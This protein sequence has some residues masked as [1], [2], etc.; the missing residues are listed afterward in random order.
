MLSSS[1]VCACKLEFA[2]ADG[3][4]AITFINSEGEIV[5][6][7][8]D[9]ALDVDS[10]IS[11]L[12]AVAKTPECE[13]GMGSLFCEGGLTVEDV[14]GTITAVIESDVEIISVTSAGVEVAGVK[15][16]TTVKVC[17]CQAYIEVDSD[18]SSFEIQTDLEVAGETL[19]TGTYASGDAATLLAD[20]E[21]ALDALGVTYTSVEV[22]ENVKEGMFTVCIYIVGD[23]GDVLYNCTPLSSCGC[24]QEYWF[25]TA[26][27]GEK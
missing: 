16:C 13:S 25:E 12:T 27:E 26:T 6:N 20:W 9:A 8:F 2:A 24:K 23:C 10:V 11:A 14:D 3:I 21:T 5:T 19:A 4:E 15:D 22:T 1:A 7:S 18:V 17:K